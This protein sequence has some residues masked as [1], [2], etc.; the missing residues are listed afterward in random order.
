MTETTTKKRTL[1]DISDDLMAINDL[2]FESGG[3]ISDPAVA[4]AIDEWFA[5]IEADE[6]RKVGNYIGL[7]REKELRCSAI[8][9]E[10]ERFAKLAT[11]LGNSAKGLKERLKYYMQLVSKNKI[12]TPR[13]NASVCGNGGKTPLLIVDIA[14][15]SV[16]PRFQKITLTIDHDIVRNALEAGEKL[17]WASLEERG[18]HLRIK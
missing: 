11:A 14:A 1:L 5:E 3:D 4:E 2:L 15:E 16:P 7:I 13:G 17:E 10:K 12:E 8:T 6:E 18:T 9:E